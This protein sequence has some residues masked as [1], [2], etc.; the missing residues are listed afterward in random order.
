MYK[1]ITELKFRN[2]HPLL[3]KILLRMKLTFA[4]LTVV[5][6]QVQASSYAQKISLSVRNAS[7]PE[8]ITQIRKQANVDFLYNNVTVAALKPITLKVHNEEL[9]QVLE[10]CFAGQ[11][12][13]F[14]I[15]NNSVLILAKTPDAQ[16]NK[17][18]AA[19]ID[20]TGTVTDDKGE[21]LAG[22]V[23][24]IKNATA[25]A[26]TDVNGRYKIRVPDAN[27]I[28]TYRF[29]GFDNQE[30]A[31]NGQTVINVTLRMKTSS[32]NDVVVVGYGTQKQKDVTGSV[33][34]VT[35]E[36]M[37]KGPQLTP[38]QLIQGKIAGVNIS[39]NSGKP[40]T[41]NT[42]RIRGG[43]SVTQ[44][45]D[46]LYV[47]DGVPIAV[48][49][50]NQSNIAGNTTNVFDQEPVNP[51]Q[52]LNPNDIES[53]SVLKDASATAIYGS[54]GAN[55]VIVITT[56]SGKQGKPQVSYNGSF[57]ISNVAKKLDVMTA[58][59]YRS[60]IRSLIAARP[61]L[62]LDDKGA[63][64]DWQDQI[65]RTA[66][67][68]DHNV[69]LSGGTDKTSYR[70]SIGYGNQQG[71]ALNSNLRQANILTN[72][73]QKALN[74]RLKFDFRLNYGQN[75]ANVAPMSSTVGG[76]AGTSMN[77]EAYVFNPTYPVYDP[78]GAYYNIPAYR[79]NPVSFSTELI[80]QKFNERVLGNLT[81]SFKIIDPLS[82][83]V[84]L[85]YSRNNT[86]R[87]SYINKSKG[88]SPLGNGLNGYASVQK[89]ADYTKLLETILR[90]NKSYGAHSLEALAGY[91]YQY[92][93][94]ESNRIQANNFLS[95]NFKWNALG[96][97]GTV[98]APTSGAGSNTLISMYA[99]ANY[100]YAD[101]YLFTGT[102]RRD[103]S[104][105]FGANNKWGYFPSGSVAW[106]I[107]KEK[108]FDVKAISDLKLRVSY[109]LTGNQDI[110]NLLSQ[111]LLNP[112]SNGY[113]IGGQRVSIV[114][115]SQF[116]N[117]DIKWEQT[118]QL[119]AGINFG[120]FN[121]RVHGTVD[122]YR[123]KTKDLLLSITLPQPSAVQSG[124]VNAGSVENK[125]IEVELGG[126][127]VDQ[128]NFGWDLNLVFARNINRVL[129]LSNDLYSSANIPT[130]PVQGTASGG[131]TQLIL[132]GQ[133]LGTFYGR[134]YTGLDA[135]GLET[136]APGG[137]QVLGNAQPKFTYGF[138]NTFTYKQWT[139][140]ANLRG[141]YGNKV[142]NLTANNLGYK[143]ILPG[144]NALASVIDDGV[145]YSQSQNYSS[146]WIQDGSFLRMDNATL[147]YNV[148]LKT[149]YISNL[150]LYLNAQNLFL[151]TKYS[152]IDPEVNAEISRTGTA[153]LGIDYLG[154][155]R[156]R[157]FSL[158]ANITF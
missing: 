51:L 107:S 10:K 54:R 19:D 62:V 141:S 100:N 98:I 70:T 63:N 22:V 137:S 157:T 26:V 108:F 20:V 55:G 1:I 126:S 109:G 44:S 25:S 82:I 28:L 132:P 111:T 7:L 29:I 118:A 2:N 138:S 83:N 133:P 14:R 105:R 12:L 97:A 64:T 154:Y 94:G 56:K 116:T 17:A 24:Q 91:S 71:I 123:K 60:V 99:R 40:G 66:Y 3:P 13:Y 115:I 110:G 74:D 50:L 84:S 131:N 75:K 57:G 88:N 150:R 149:Q 106:R 47:I 23:V 125:G 59:E 15:E 119:D 148:K 93:Y 36:N 85:G 121:N 8:L 102:V 41:S 90:F 45:N 16:S 80:D 103:G 79:V 78:N 147:G 77:F 37:N 6:M 49:N 33:G 153:P 135:Q 146:R 27:T 43:Q 38:Q 96:A 67:T 151:I 156:A 46:P 34:F 139:L 30:I 127:V 31:V 143:I 122:F 81:T 87:N 112:S 144:K 61:T 11:P 42:I 72:V 35:A 73:T 18:A 53:I 65:Y 39:Q 129:S 124:I 104:S 9:A 128:K 113:I 89:F 5:F 76:E 142:Y 130:S 69:A 158:G 117:P 155:P 68:N 145:S 92:F 101:R 4:I 21:P 52:T 32:L 58:D 152:G 48:S 140:I 136:Y 134:V 86:E 114:G 120:L 95:D